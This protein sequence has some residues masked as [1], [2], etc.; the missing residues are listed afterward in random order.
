MRKK[1]VKKE[2]GEKRSKH[3]NIYIAP[4]STHESWRITAAEGV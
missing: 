1:K 4:K 2:E 3:T